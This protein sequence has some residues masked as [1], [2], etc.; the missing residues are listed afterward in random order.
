MNAA[1]DRA[2]PERTHDAAGRRIAQRLRFGLSAITTLPW[3]QDIGKIEDL[4]TLLGVLDSK[5][6]GLMVLDLPADIQGPINLPKGSWSVERHTRRIFLEAEPDPVESWPSTRRKQLRRA[7]REGMIVTRSEDL[8][9]LV[10]LHQAP[11]ARKGLASDPR[12]LHRLLRELLDERE[13]HAWVVRDAQGEPVAGG[14]FH[15]AGDQRCIYGFGGQF[16]SSDAGTSSR[17]S[18]MLI[19]AS[20]R[21][22]AA[23]GATAFDFGG[24]QDEGVDRF[25]AEFGAERIPKIRLVRIRGLWK[26]ILRWRRPDLFSR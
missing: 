26:P 13:T 7:E 23:N 24:S 12:A 8:D 21:H 10:T 5:E 15:G 2:F 16:R 20:M 17:A 14:V 18:V 1:W 6:A 9:L 22:A 19:A 4:P 25:Y 3:A 11:R